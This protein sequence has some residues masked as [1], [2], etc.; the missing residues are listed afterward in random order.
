MVTAKQLRWSESPFL[1][2]TYKQRLPVGTQK[3]V[4]NKSKQVTKHTTE[5]RE[6]KI[7]EMTRFELI[8]NIAY[9]HT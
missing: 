4:L 8:V 6:S 1:L 5:K 3:S 2:C 9:L 7:Q